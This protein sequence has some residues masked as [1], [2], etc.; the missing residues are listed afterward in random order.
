MTPT[1][2]GHGHGQSAL[3][4]HHAQHGHADH[5]GLYN[6]DVAH[7]Y[8]DVD[9]RSVLVFCFGLMAIVAVVAF[10]MYGMFLVLE[11]QA[12]QN[13]P[14]ISPLAVPAG[15]EPPEP[16]LLRNEPSY[17]RT[18]KTDEQR[19]L[20]GYAWVDE[21]AGTVRIPID[22]AKKQLLQRGLPVRADGQ[23]DPWMGTYSAAR[24]EASGGRNIPLRPGSAEM[25][26]AVQPAAVPPPAAPKS[27]GH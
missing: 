9:V 23:V 27:G 15:Q 19:I 22:E 16:R 25:P 14:V 3:D 7:E 11:N 2:S 18:V 17:L 20:D 10:A 12:A 26:P 13:D 21:K 5:D 24:G 8:S 4:R 6:E 1:N